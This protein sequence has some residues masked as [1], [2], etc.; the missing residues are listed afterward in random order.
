MD[1]FEKF[2]NDFKDGKLEPH[3][4][5][6]AVPDNSENAVKVSSQP[7]SNIYGAQDN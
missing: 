4:K 3:L 5:S 2:L 6:E 7:T 1:T